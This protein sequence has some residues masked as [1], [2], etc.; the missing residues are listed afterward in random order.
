MFKSPNCLKWDK[1]SEKMSKLWVLD[2]SHWILNNTNSKKAKKI[3]DYGC[4][5]FL[6]GEFLAAEFQEV[7][8]YDINHDALEKAK[9]RQVSNSFFYNNLNAISNNS[10]D[11]VIVS[12]VIQYFENYE[13][14]DLFF[15]FVAQKLKNNGKSILLIADII[16]KDYVS[17]KD[18]LENLFFAAQHGI[19]L[20]MFVHLFK[21]TFTKSIKLL[22]I[23]K[24]EISKI[25]EK[26]GFRSIFLD[27]NLTL[28]RRRYSCVFS[29]INLANE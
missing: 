11:I 13:A 21:A 28:S 4:S 6:T 3:L 9:S 17:W 29:L 5:D 23:D 26:H 24:A 1:R 27:K 15:A 22:K 25:A 18:A 12:S 7:H 20:P 14:I 19:M 16:P 2:V 8:G 10:F